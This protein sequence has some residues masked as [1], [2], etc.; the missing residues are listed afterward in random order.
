MTKVGALSKAFLNP[1]Y[2]TVVNGQS[3]ILYF[4]LH[5]VNRFFTK[6][7]LMASLDSLVDGL[8]MEIGADKRKVLL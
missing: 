4:I 7:C 1:S 5:I 3:V 8:G 2:T 6:T